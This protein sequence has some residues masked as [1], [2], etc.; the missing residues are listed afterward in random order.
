MALG[1]ARDGL[2][3]SLAPGHD[4]RQAGHIA[5]RGMVSG[6]AVHGGVL[7]CGLCVWAKARWRCSVLIRPR[8]SLAFC[9]GNPVLQQRVRNGEDHRAQEQ[10]EHPE[11]EK[12]AD[13]AKYDQQQR[14]IGSTLDQDGPQEVVH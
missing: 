2:T 4:A 8:Q 3:E 6:R 7:S 5:V 13:D 10:A 11:G 12:A 9:F 1:R 14:Q